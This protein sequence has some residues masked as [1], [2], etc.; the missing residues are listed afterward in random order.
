MANFIIY[1]I[2]ELIIY[3]DY[4]QPQL[5]KQQYKIKIKNY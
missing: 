1:A 4:C 5:L 3:A 2:I